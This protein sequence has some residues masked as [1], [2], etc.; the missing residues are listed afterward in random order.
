MSLM[1]LLEQEKIDPNDKEKVELLQKFYQEGFTQGM[2][3][4]HPEY[5]YSIKYR[6]VV[7][8]LLELFRDTINE[9][10]LKRLELS[11][12][13]LDEFKRENMIL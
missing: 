10:C 2:I 5:D 7:T 12:D 4:S 3:S 1:E 11:L 8:R 6:Q 9:R 13:K